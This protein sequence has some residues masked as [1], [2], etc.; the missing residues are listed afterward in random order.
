MIARHP[1]DPDNAAPD[2]MCVSRGRF[3]DP[4]ACNERGDA[5]RKARDKAARAKM[6]ADGFLPLG[7]WARTHG[8]AYDTAYKRCQA[9][10]L[11]HTEMFH[12]YWIAPGVS[13]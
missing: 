9:G 8:I 13:A 10:T 2:W 6:R 12:S 1:S 5:N 4:M 7:D 3:K 11:P